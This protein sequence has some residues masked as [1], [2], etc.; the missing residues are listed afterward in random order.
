MTT[1]MDYT[2]EE[3]RLL[4]QAPAWASLLIL[5]AYESNRIVIAYKL[6]RVL[7][8]ISATVPHKPN[9]D[10][11][12]AVAATVRA[13]LVPQQ[14]LALPRDLLA[15]RQQRLAHC[16]QVAA[17]LAQKVPEAEA[18][19]FTGWLIDLGQRVAWA[20][21][22]LDLRPSR[23]TEAQIRSGLAVELLTSALTFPFHVAAPAPSRMMTIDGLE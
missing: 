4:V 9:T 7:A 13:G 11:I 5:E 12:R 22:G 6:V 3:W 20:G 23:A 15:T 17:V 2:V 1:Q 14:L 10:L 19:A 21:D 18:V 8:G 16:R